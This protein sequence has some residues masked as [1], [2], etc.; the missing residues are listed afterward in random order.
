MIRTEQEKSRI[1]VGIKAIIDGFE[2]KDGVGDRLCDLYHRWRDEKEYEDWEDY[3]DAILKIVGPELT[4]VKI[5]KKPFGFV[6]LFEGI[7]VQY[8]VSVSGRTLYTGYKFK[9]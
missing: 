4:V 5:T 3:E 7:Q 8:Y 9:F 6:F 1:R 2:K